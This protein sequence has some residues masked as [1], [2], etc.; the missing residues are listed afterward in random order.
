M[1]ALPLVT[2][3]VPTYNRSARLGTC[4]EGLRA[5]TYGNF[6]VIVSDNASADDTE[7]V[8]R[9]F[10]AK[11][12][13]IGYYRQERNIGAVSNFEFLRQQARGKYFM[14]VADDDLPST[15]Y[16]EQCVACMEHEPE[17]VLAGA[18]AEYRQA[19]V[20]SHVGNVV[21]C[22]QDGSVR[23]ILHYFHAV[24]DNAIF[25]G[26]YRTAALSRCSLQGMNLL[27]AD[28]L[29]VAQILY[30]GKAETLDSTL[31]IRDVGGASSSHRQMLRAVGLPE[32][33]DP[34]YT[35][36]LVVSMGFGIA[37][38]ARA[39]N[40]NLGFVRRA[41]LALLVMADLSYRFL[42]GRMLWVLYSFAVRI[43]LVKRKPSR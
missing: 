40:E 42:R 38:K 13:R 33:L 12:A 27:G 31:L 11:D 30:F 3:G 6:H 1:N 43:K 19:G 5:Q 22:M 8:V 9:E 21:N 10:M 26:V 4:L 37:A 7:S 17:I 41:M 16:L 18:K 39:L 29:W 35:T 28:W 23:R 14:W 15:N 20:L 34:F 36:A 25:Y 2:V 24:Q 32:W